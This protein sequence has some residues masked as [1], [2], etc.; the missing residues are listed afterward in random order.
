MKLTIEPN[1]LSLMVVNERVPTVA[2]VVQVDEVFIHCALVF[3]RSKLC[4]HN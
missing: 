4:D 2:I 3:R 1:L